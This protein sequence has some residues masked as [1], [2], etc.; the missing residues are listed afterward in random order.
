MEL[1]TLNKLILLPLKTQLVIKINKVLP[2]S[3]PVL[4][5]ALHHPQLHKIYIPKTPN[6][7]DHIQILNK[8]FYFSTLTNKKM[9]HYQTCPQIGLFNHFPPQQYAQS[10]KFTQNPS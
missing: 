7:L 9:L 10:P 3:K 8:I 4:V 6:L 2:R 1:P 5:S